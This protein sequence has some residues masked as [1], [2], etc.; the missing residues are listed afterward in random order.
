MQFFKTKKNE[1]EILILEYLE[2]IHRCVKSFKNS[3]DEFFHCNQLSD[4][5]M[6]LERLTHRFE[7]EGDDKRR[8]IELLMYS[9]NLIPQSR[10]DILALI[11]SM[12]KIPSKIETV[13]QSIYSENIIIPKSFHQRTKELV[14]VNL[15]AVN[16]AINL[17]KAFLN[18]SRDIPDIVDIIDQLE[19]QSDFMERKLIYDLFRS[20]EISDFQRIILRHLVLTIGGI[21]DNAENFSDRV[22]IAS[23]KRYF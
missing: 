17:F 3:M 23:V 10:G 15:E 2:T 21:S 18:N 6:R 8:K 12:D 1:V 5:F 9:R 4:E 19:S 11:E 16:E 7:S 20:D 22:N 14:N 13:L